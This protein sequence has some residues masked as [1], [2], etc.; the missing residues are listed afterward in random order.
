MLKKPDSSSVV[1]RSQG[2]KRLAEVSIDSP[3]LVKKFK[4]S[5]LNGKF[6][7]DVLPLEMLVVVSQ[8]HQ[9]P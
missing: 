2:E 1:T 9:A 8:P 5:L 4:K 6:E 3:S 7:E